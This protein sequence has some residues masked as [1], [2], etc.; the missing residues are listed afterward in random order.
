MRIFIFIGAL[1]VLD[2]YVFQAFRSL[3][4]SWSAPLRNA[5]YA[6]FWLVPLIALSTVI[7]ASLTDTAQWNK[8]F[9][10]FLR[11]FLFIAY[12]SK[13]LILPVLVIDDLRRVGLYLYDQWGG[14]GRFDYGRS[15][16]LSQIGILLGG[17]PFVSLTYGVIRN[18]YRYKVFREKVSL[19]HLPAA[20]RGLKIIQISDIHSGSFIFREPVK[21]AIELINGEKPDLVFFTG[22][23]VNYR[24]DEMDPFLDIFSGIKA[25]YGVFS[26]LGNH[27]YGDYVRWRH[28]GE[29]ETNLNNL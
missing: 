25:T 16:F 27:D 9:Y 28:P 26:V 18:P 23:M 22:D 20:L 29:K 11:T 13:L 8:T 15:R 7:A 6:A 21:R 14:P 19:P 24:A 12:L 3:S 17:L 10:T 1:L 2:F 4:Q 5:V